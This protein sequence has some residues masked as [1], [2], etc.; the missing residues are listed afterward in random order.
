LPGWTIAALLPPSPK[1]PFSKY[2]ADA[3]P[4][5][6][7]SKFINEELAKP[8]SALEMALKEVEH[9]KKKKKPTYSMMWLPMVRLI[10]VFVGTLSLWHCPRDAPG[11]SSW[12]ASHRLHLAWPRWPRLAHGPVSWHVGG[13]QVVHWAG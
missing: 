9:Q 5:H 13:N 1:S 8:N 6:F 11:A 2:P 3:C 7:D 4:T 12:R 10:V